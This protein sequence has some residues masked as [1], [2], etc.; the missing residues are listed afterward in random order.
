M[1][2]FLLTY[3]TEPIIDIFEREGTPFRRLKIDDELQWEG[4]KFVDL[5]QA[6]WPRLRWSDRRI[7][8]ID[9]QMKQN[10]IKKIIVIG[11]C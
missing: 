10:M 9:K 2:Y 4:L 6:M 7:E 8:D 11:H 5:F 3:G 1:D